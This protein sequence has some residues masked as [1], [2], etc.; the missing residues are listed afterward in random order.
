MTGDRV[1]LSLL[2]ADIAVG[3]RIGFLNPAHVKTLAEDI[4]AHGQHDPVHVQQLGHAGNPHWKLL[5][6]L[7]RLRA[8]TYA[9]LS[10]VNAIEVAGP[11]ASQA[12]LRRLELSENLDHQHRRPIERAMLVTARARLE[13]EAD[14]PGR[15]GERAQVRAGRT[16]QS[17]S[18]RITDAGWR[19]RTADAMGC[20]LSTL[21]KLQRIHRDVV[22]ALPDLA[23][24]L[25]FHPLGESL[26]GMTELA[27]VPEVDRRKGALAIIPAMIG[28]ASARR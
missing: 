5:A 11:D 23:E 15:V 28:R 12:E 19:K 14:H 3:E 22:G 18:V 24:R 21:E 8:A 4:K 16:R 1:V 26:S 7:H 17:A 9:G 25:N 13:E 2:I 10:A 27:Q 20:S 6:G